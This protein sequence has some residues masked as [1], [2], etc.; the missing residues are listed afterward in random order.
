MSG[1]VQPGGYSALSLFVCVCVCVSLSLCTWVYWIVR[2]RC[3]RSDPPVAPATATGE[4]G[5]AA[6]HGGLT[7]QRRSIGLP[8]A[9]AVWNVDVKL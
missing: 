3:G 6:S 8:A 5:C 7:P 9:L 1:A 4:G 2:R